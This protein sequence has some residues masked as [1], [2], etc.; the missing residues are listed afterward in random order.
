MPAM[1]GVIPVAK[2][3]SSAE[4]KRVKRGVIPEQMEDK[5]F[6]YWFNGVLHFHRSWTGFCVYQVQF[7]RTPAGWEMFEALVN[8]DPTE[9]TETDDRRDSLLISYL[10]HVLL[11]DAPHPF[12]A[13]HSDGVRAGLQEWSSSG[14]SSPLWKEVGAGTS[15]S[16]ENEEE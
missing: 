8:R 1:S 11:L 9:Y 12:P 14:R 4:M 6:V 7:R 5:W 2:T 3:F 10:I 13:S 15:S 16:D